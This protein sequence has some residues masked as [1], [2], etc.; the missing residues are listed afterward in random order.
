MRYI[1]CNDLRIWNSR[2]HCL[3][4]RNRLSATLC[5]RAAMFSI[6]LPLV[7]ILHRLRAIQISI[8]HDQL[9]NRTNSLGSSGGSSSVSSGS[10]NNG[11]NNEDLLIMSP[12]TTLGKEIPLKFWNQTSDHCRCL[13]LKSN[14]TS[15]FVRSCYP[16]KSNHPTTTNKEIVATWTREFSPK[17][18]R[19]YSSN[20]GL[21]RR[22]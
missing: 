17:K 12:N 7:L 1:L 21:P 10:S 18:L 16:N 4:K 11:G 9:N 19:L 13:F 22:Q 14:F 20:H 5:S 6:S 3:S 2:Q 15:D 8:S